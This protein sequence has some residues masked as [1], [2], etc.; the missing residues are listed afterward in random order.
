MK[1]Q[2]TNQKSTKHRY[3]YF[4]VMIAL[5]MN[6]KNVPAIL[7]HNFSMYNVI[8]TYLLILFIPMWDI[9]PQCLFSTDDGLEQSSELHP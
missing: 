4:K 7:V 5:Q 1:A 3:H 8:L 6:K 9:R 2:V